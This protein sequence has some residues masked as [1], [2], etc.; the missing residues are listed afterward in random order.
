MAPLAQCG[1]AR[2]LAQRGAITATPPPPRPRRRRPL[3]GPPRTAARPA[4]EAEPAAARTPPP[5]REE[6]LPPLVEEFLSSPSLERPAGVEPAAQLRA[7]EAFWREMRRPGPP[8]SPPAVVRR[9]AGSALPAPPEYDVVVA[10]GTLGLLVALALAK[11][12]RRVAVVERRRAEGRDQEWNCSR[13]ELARLE[14]MGLLTAAELEAA[15]ATEWAAARVGFAGGGADVAADGVLTLGVSPRR[16]LAAARARLEALGGVVLERAPLRRV[17]VHDDGVAVELGGGGGEALDAADVN[18]PAALDAADV[19]ADE[20]GTGSSSGSGSSSNGDGDGSSRPRRQVTAR[21]LIDTMGHFSP[22]AKQARGRRRPGGVVLVLGGCAEG[23]APAA[24]RSSDLLR[25]LGDADGDLQL[26]WE[27][28]PAAGGAARTFYLFA[29]TT[30]EAARPPLAALLERFLRD[31]PAY[32]G[33]P[34]AALRFRRLLVGGLPCF[35]GAAPLPPAFDRVLQAGDAAAAQSPLS[36]G[37]FAALLRHLPRL[38]DGVDDAL[39]CG[40]LARRDLALLQPY[41]PVIS[42][43]W[44]FQRAMSVGVGQLA[45]PAGG[46]P[47][48]GGWLPPNQVN[49]LLRANFAVMRALG[50]RA[51]R[52]FLCDAVQLAPLAATMAGMMLAD[53]VAVARVARQVGPRA[54]GAWFLHFF[55]LAAYTAAHH[56]LAPLLR[57]LAPRSFALRRLLEAWRYGCSADYVYEGPAAAAAATEASPTAATAAA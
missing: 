30:A 25:S 42:C 29:Y 49:R 50:D 10:G 24:N 31:L 2:L 4:V 17:A 14:S 36:F 53:P 38:A 3:G 9:L 7:A 26:F 15:V 12:G 33:A 13:G 19:R 20:A 54:L 21:L 55:A 27:A 52:P 51:L 48:R 41:S 28:F 46:A 44:L 22:I 6:P 43:C 35:P 8:P 47:R 11:R 57:P 5:R 39:R 45:A 23:V 18:R 40:R 34:L 16:L 56:L 1:G 37:G 32:A